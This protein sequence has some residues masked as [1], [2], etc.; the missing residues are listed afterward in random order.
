LESNG[1]LTSA[2]MSS[3]RQFVFCLLAATFGA[4][5]V[6]CRAPESKTQTPAAPVAPADAVLP[7]DEQVHRWVSPKPNRCPVVPFP[8]PGQ[9][10]PDEEAARRTSALNMRPALQTCGREFLARHPYSDGGTIR[11]T[12]VID[13][14]GD[15]T[16]VTGATRDTDRAFAACVMRA[17]VLT[18][19]DPPSA[20]IARLGVPVTLGTKPAASAP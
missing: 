9:V 17:A 13:C 19:F 2:D 15:V 20:G 4:G 11:V 14:E 3:V 5:L 7:D 6:G 16:A 1:L 12:L 18:P 8:A 10:P